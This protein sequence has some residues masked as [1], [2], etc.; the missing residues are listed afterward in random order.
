MDSRFHDTPS[1]TR[2]FQYNDHTADV[3]IHAWGSSLS[4]SFENTAL[5]ISAYMINLN[6]V[7]I[8]ETSKKVHASGSD[9]IDLLY[10]F[11]NETLYLFHGEGFVIKKV[12]VDDLDI[13]KMTVYATCF[14][15]TYDPRRHTG[16][17][18]IKAV[19]FEDMHVA[20]A[21]PYDIFVVVDI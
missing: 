4:E 7:E 13:E 2:M 18:E 1:P 16:G 6:T 12:V 15:E 8:S 20:T 14:G 11:L 5:A 10:S 9:L 19:T 21:A 17:T 3:Q